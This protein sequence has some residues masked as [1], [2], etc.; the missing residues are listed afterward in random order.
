MV[1]ASYD[2][3]SFS[4]IRH[5]GLY[6]DLHGLECVMK[7]GLQIKFNHILIVTVYKCAHA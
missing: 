5:G 4:L 1:L 6:R 7:L 3:I 2:F